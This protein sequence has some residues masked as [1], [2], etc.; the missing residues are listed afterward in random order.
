MKIN[1]LP[2]LYFL[3][4]PKTAGTSFRLWL[5]RLFKIDEVLDIHHLAELENVDDETLKAH[6]FFSGH[7]GWRMMERAKSMGLSCEVVTIFREPSEVYLSGLNHTPNDLQSELFEFE[8]SSD[9]NRYN[10]NFIVRFVASNGNEVREPLPLQ[11]HELAVA[12]LRLNNMRFFGMVD[13]WQGTA[14]LFA[15]VFC[16]PLRAMETR[17]NISTKKTVNF[18]V[19][20]LRTRWRVSDSLD[21]ELFEHAKVLFS[22]RLIEA[23]KSL[24]VASDAPF[25]AYEEPLLK[26]FLNTDQGI[27]RLCNASIPVSSDIIQSGFEHRFPAED[28]WAIWADKLKSSIFLPLAAGKDFNIRFIAGITMSEAIRDRMRISIAGIW[29]EH[30]MRY[31]ESEPNSGKWRVEYTVNCPAGL[32]PNQQYTQIEFEIPELVTVDFGELKTHLGFSLIG[33]IVIAELDAVVTSPSETLSDD[34][35]ASFMNED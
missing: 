23:Q 14:I 15:Y 25:E 20:K 17:E 6:R 9:A 12:Q 29:R 7:F 13:D 1:H 34:G 21:F 8:A 26:R 33:E 22:K 11:A 30:T 4:I 16:L 28:G 27:A 32:I 19:E 3:H 31:F 5:T 10:N 2:S 18:D 35:I 24:G